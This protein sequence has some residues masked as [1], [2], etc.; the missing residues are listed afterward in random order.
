V[1][2]AREHGVNIGPD[3]PVYSLFPEYKPFANWDD[4]KG[5]ITLADLMTMTPGL[6][7]DDR[8]SSSPG[9]ED[10]M[11][12]QQRQPDWHRYTL[13]LPMA[14]DPGGEHAIYCSASLNLVGGMV[15]NATRRWLPEV[16]DE[17]FARPLK[18]RSYHMN[19][20]PNGEAYLGGGIYMRPRDLL[21]LGQLYLSGGAWNGRRVVSK[22]WAEVST[23][24]HTVFQP[25]MESDVDHGYGY[26]WHTRLLRVGSRVFRDY[27]AAG[28][29]GQYVL[30]I[31]DLDVVVVMTGGSYGERDKFYPWE[32]EFVPR[33]IIPAVVK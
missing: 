5:K 14:H 20:M 30:V 11:Q 33:Y 31:P 8:D 23:A 6:A 19:L 26:G 2:A 25:V 24:R 32:S 21:K 9:A 17:Y 13:D 15:R 10:T 1:G 22:S 4:R 7:C 27:Y 16:F 12:E 3:T 29:G 18:I 28:N